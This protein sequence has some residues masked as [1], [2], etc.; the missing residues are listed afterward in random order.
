MP[1]IVGLFSDHESTRESESIF[2]T[3]VERLSHLG[4]LR[5][6][7]FELLQGTVRIGLLS[8]DPCFTENYEGFQLLAFSQTTKDEHNQDLM[9]EGLKDLKTRDTLSEIPEMLIAVGVTESELRVMRS[10]DGLRPLYFS[11]IPN[12]LMLSS[13]QKAIWAYS[14][15]TPEPLHPGSMLRMSAENG[16]EIIQGYSRSRPRIILESTQ[17]DHLANLRTYLIQSFKKIY[18]RKNCGVLFSGGVDSSLA[19]LLTKEEDR[20][21]LLISVATPESKD[22][23]KT[24]TAASALSL[25]H[26]LVPLDADLVWE[27]LPEVIYAIESSNRMDVEIAVPF[28]LAAKKARA[29]GCE[30]VVSGQGPDELFAGYA[31]YERGFQEKGDKAVADELWSDFSKTHETNIARDTKAIEYHGV[32]SF[33]PFLD[34]K[35]SQAALTT[36]VGLLI[37]PKSNP[38]RKILFRSLAKKMGLS[39]EMADAQKHAT[40]YSSGSSKAL[41]EAV[42]KYVSDSKGLSKREI[43][44]PVNDVLQFISREIGMPTRESKEIEMDMRPTDRLIESVGQL[45]TRYLG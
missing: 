11:K 28:F 25:D 21:P 12:G 42:A 35:F 33:F 24:Q 40:Q 43:S 38:S 34:V 17:D 4:P 45:A 18:K 27:I 26:E 3:M 7:S 39:A 1:G 36:P 10:L 16:M 19:A 37:D 44:L 22:F 6:F 8:D 29:L 41:Q 31:R 15:T 23:E 14:S 32:R 2:S 13:E 30:V 5:E 20:N 9:V